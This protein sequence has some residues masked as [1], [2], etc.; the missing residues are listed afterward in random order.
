MSCDGITIIQDQNPITILQTV[1]VINMCASNPV[2]NFIPFWFSATQ[3]QTVFTLPAIS[4][5][6]WVA[7]NGTSQSSAKLPTA[8]F[9]I[10]ENVLTLSSGMDAGDTVFGMIQ[11]A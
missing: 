5:A 2:S 8:D 7:I 10:N 6:A 11:V 9:T 3:G 4:L 1:E